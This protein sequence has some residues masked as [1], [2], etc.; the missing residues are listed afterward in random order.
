MDLDWYAVQSSLIC[1]RESRPHLKCGESG[2]QISLP[3]LSLQERG[4]K[5]QALLK[6][7]KQK[8]GIPFDVPASVW[9]FF[10]TPL[11][12][13]IPFHYVHKS[14]SYHA[15]ESNSCVAYRYWYPEAKFFHGVSRGIR[16]SES[17]GGFQMSK[18][19]SGVGWG[20]QINI[21]STQVCIQTSSFLFLNKVMH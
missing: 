11:H 15:P 13:K 6:E 4:I 20:R 21:W 3:C 10:F 5:H 16:G 8:Y 7:R 19:N 17:G 14:Q 12:L 2:A 1:E 9:G 18:L